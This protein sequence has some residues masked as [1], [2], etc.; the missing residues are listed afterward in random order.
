MKP[1]KAQ[2]VDAIYD[3]LTTSVANNRFFEARARGFRSELEFENYV[4]SKK[5]SIL[6]GGQFLFRQ[7]NNLGFHQLVYVTVTF[8]DPK[9]YLNLYAKI[10]Q[11]PIVTDLFFIKLEPLIKWSSCNI[12]I[13]RKGKVIQNKSIPC[14]TYK[15]LK[16]DSGKFIP[17][18][19]ASIQNLFPV[20]NNITIC[21]QKNK[22]A[23]NYLMDYPDEDIGE[24]LANRYLIDVMLRNYRKGMIDFDFIIEN[25]SGFLA[26]ETKEK[27]AGGS[28]NNKY[29]GWDS[30]R[31]SWYLYLKQRIGLDGWYVIREVNNQTQRNL[32]AWKYVTIDEFAKAASW[33]SEM[34]GGGNS[35][36]ITAPYSLFKVL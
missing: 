16:Y 31:L 34:G 22:S 32:I 8:E 4:K 36:T 14:P 1:T 17:S 33:L 35:G 27:D 3:I 24:I 12:P 25:E 7:R 23:Y 2:I 9:N 11:L 15:I 21:S 26:V 19:V 13:S 10:S 20:K 28:G 5:L 30:R 6:T 29:F 18:N